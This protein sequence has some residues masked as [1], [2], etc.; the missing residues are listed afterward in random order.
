MRRIII[1]VF[2]AVLLWGCGKTVESTTS[3][4]NKLYFDSWVSIQKQKHPEY[5]WKQT[6]LG[7]WILE[8][9]EGTGEAL[10]EF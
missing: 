10:G 9:K 5:V 7:A 8:D 3:E 6:G 1:F 2:A 4:I